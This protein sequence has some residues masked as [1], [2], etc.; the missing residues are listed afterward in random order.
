M[1]TSPSTIDEPIRRNHLFSAVIT[2]T[3]ATPTL[4]CSETFDHHLHDCI[5][6]S[7]RMHM[8]EIFRRTIPYARLISHSEIEGQG[9]AQVRLCPSF[10]SVYHHCTIPFPSCLLKREH[11]RLLPSLP[12]D[13]HAF[14]VSLL[15]S[16]WK[17][18]PPGHRSAAFLGQ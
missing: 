6:T 2:C 3:T 16:V 12:M 5:T 14:N 18:H 11:N 8:K 15:A 13:E 17:I 10:H 1:K 4:R 9:R 7:I